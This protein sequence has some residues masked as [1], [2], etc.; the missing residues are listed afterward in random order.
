MLH[1]YIGCVAIFYL[2]M[3]FCVVPACVMFGCV[4]SCLVGE[5]G[6]SASC[7]S[8]ELVLEMNRSLSFKYFSD[9]LHASKTYA[10]SS[11]VLSKCTL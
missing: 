5:G 2:F 11:C 7:A 1:P 4:L 9:N 6:G 8:S 10:Y 3:C